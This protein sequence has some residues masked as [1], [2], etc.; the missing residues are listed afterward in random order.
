VF[1]DPRVTTVSTILQHVRKGRITGLQSLEEGDAEVIE[2]VILDTSPLQGKAIAKAGLGDGIAVG[3]VVRGDEVTIP[4]GDF[5][6]HVD[7]RLVLFAERAQVAHVE[8][9][10]RVA[11]EYF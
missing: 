1:V 4:G 8:R 9:A 2:G 6:L 11:L 7:D 5:V 10:L 3:A